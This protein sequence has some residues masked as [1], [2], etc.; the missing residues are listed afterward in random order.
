MNIASCRR[1]V[2]IAV[3]GAAVAPS[4]C[5]KAPS[6]P[7][8][9]PPPQQSAAPQPAVASAQ[10]DSAVDP[11]S[12]LD[13]PQT[14]PGTTV[15]T[16]IDPHTLSPS[17]VKFGV[18]PKRSPDVEYQPG[19]ILME[20]GDQAIRSAGGDGMSWSFDANA[21]NV[22]DFQVGKIVFA[23]GRAVGR[24][25]VLKRDGSTVTAIL[26][27]VPLSDVIR[28]GRFIMDQPVDADK[29]VTYSRPTTR[30]STT[31]A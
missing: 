31:A 18:A 30:G 1:A 15:L 23:T 6:P 20:H 5:K 14:S 22:S 12:W 27:P 16:A 11:P 26:G 9:S 10:Q 28:N 2:A 25:L 3:L 21:P 19:V 17:E 29:M 24:I 13:H 4:A 8:P 7:P